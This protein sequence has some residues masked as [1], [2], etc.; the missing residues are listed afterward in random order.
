MTTYCRDCGETIEPPAR[1]KLADT[2]LECGEIRAQAEADYRRTCIVP[3]CSKGGYTYITNPE[4]A[5]GIHRK[6]G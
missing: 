6:G 4:M 2:C 1:R 3:I 5:K